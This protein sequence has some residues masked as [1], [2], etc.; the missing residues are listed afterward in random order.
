MGHIP[1]NQDNDDFMNASAEEWSKPE[2]PAPM[3]ERK[4]DKTNRWGATMPEPPEAAAPNR[5]GSEPIE[6]TRPERERPEKKGN[7]KWWVILIVVVVVLCLC[8]CVVLFGLPLL[9]LNLIPTDA[10]QF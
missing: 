1:D 8:A 2:T 9:G 4:P 10:L 5:W 6:T 3:P 7:S